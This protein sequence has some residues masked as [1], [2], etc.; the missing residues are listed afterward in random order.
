[1]NLVFTQHLYKG[2]CTV[3]QGKDKFDLWFYIGRSQIHK[4]PMSKEPWWLPAPKKCLNLLWCLDF[5]FLDRNVVRLGFISCVYLFCN[6]CSLKR[7]LIKWV[8]NSGKKNLCKTTKKVG[9][10]TFRHF[11]HLEGYWQQQQKKILSPCKFLQSIFK[12][13]FNVTLNKTSIA[14]CKLFAVV[15][16][17]SKIYHNFETF[18]FPKFL[19]GCDCFQCNLCEAGKSATK[20]RSASLR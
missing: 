13:S 12:D 18:G 1:M 11:S 6:L 9:L 19:K 20:H 8:P 3:I 4:A 17:N 16:F 5:C 14:A 10:E 15:F 2:L 7:K